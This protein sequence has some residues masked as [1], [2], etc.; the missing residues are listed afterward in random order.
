MRG[1]SR[2]P[3]TTRAAAA[4]RGLT[5]VEMLVV[6]GLLVTM[7]TIIASIFTAATTAL[8]VAQVNTSLDTELRRIDGIIRQDLQGVTCRMTPGTNDPADSRGY[9][10]YSEGAFADRQGEDTDDTIAFTTQAPEG[11]FFTG[12]MWIPGSATGASNGGIQPITVTSKLA[13]VIYFVRGDRLYRRVLLIRPQPA[14]AGKSDEQGNLGLGAAPALSTDNVNP[15]NPPNTINYGSATGGYTSTPALGLVNPT[16]GLPLPVSWQGMND[17]SARPRTNNTLPAGALMPV[18]NTLGDLTNRENRFARPRFSNDFVTSTTG[19]VPPDG[20][21]DDL[22]LN[23]VPDRYPTLYPAALL[24]SNK[25]PGHPRI[26]F[27]TIAGATASLDTMAFPYVFPGAYSNADPGTLALGSVN[28]LFPYIPGTSPPQAFPA[29]PSGGSR[30]YFNNHSPLVE[31]DSL[32][33]P[34]YTQPPLNGTS[35]PHFWGYPTWRETLSPAWTDPVLRPNIGGATGFGGFTQNAGLS[36][37]PANYRAL[38]RPGTTSVFDMPNTV[39]EEDLLATG[40]RSFD[41][42]VYDPNTKLYNSFTTQATTHNLISSTGIRADRGP[43]YVDLGYAE[44]TS[45]FSTTPT[46]DSVL[47]VLSTFGHEG[48]IP[49]LVTDY[50]S[51]AQFRVLLYAAISLPG[52]ITTSS[53]EVLSNIGDN[54]PGISRMRRIW[55]SWSTDYMRAPATPTTAVFNLGLAPPYVGVGTYQSLGYTAATDFGP[56]MAS[57]PPPYPAPIRSLQI[58]IRINDSDNERV[59]IMTIRQDFAEKQ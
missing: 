7:M 20:E 44:L 53:Y 27:E 45:G 34:D 28:W 48:R 8:N 47:G 51:D 5:L 18:F 43:G 37:I 39:Y 30:E 14:F 42:K 26:V 50:R 55:D 38:P 32:P 59:R 6:V 40:V 33:L 3:R 2:S 24:A 9:F 29:A 11:Q 56:A 21:A 22:N 35:S 1:G 25:A 4:R 54:T 58:Q 17:I 16:T 19:N 12:R 23:G 31:G 36:N 52:L 57:Y 41:V 13:E 49:P 15:L 46:E 10:E